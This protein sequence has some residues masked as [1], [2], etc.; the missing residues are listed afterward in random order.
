MISLIKDMD[1]IKK[2]KTKNIKSKVKKLRQEIFSCLNFLYGKKRFVL[3]KSIS[4]VFPG[5]IILCIGNWRV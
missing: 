1:L 4:Q 2:V 3:H 5:H